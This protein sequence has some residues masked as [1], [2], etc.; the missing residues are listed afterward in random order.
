MTTFE[1][2]WAVGGRTTVMADSPEE[3]HAQAQEL[4]PRE[5]GDWVDLDV[6]PLES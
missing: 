3:A 5:S 4:L 6:I 1:V 2:N